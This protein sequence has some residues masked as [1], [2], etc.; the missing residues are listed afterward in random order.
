[1]KKLIKFGKQFSRHV[2][3]KPFV[4]PGMKIKKIIRILTGS[5]ARIKIIKPWLNECIKIFT[6][7][8]HHNNMRLYRSSKISEWASEIFAWILYEVVWNINLI[9][10]FIVCY[11]FFI[12]CDIP[13]FMLSKLIMQECSNFWNAEIMY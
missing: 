4:K 11:V 13:K 2:L 8:F 3:C 1:M 12:R 6:I 7:F 9:L 10:I 5:Q